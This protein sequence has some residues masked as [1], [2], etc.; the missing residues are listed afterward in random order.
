M[1]LLQCFERVHHC[2]VSLEEYMACKTSL[3]SCSFCMDSSYREYFEKVGKIIVGMTI[4]VLS[5]WMQSLSIKGNL[6]GGSSMQYVK[7]MERMEQ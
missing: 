7:Y 1:F 3:E 4:E 5:C 2:H 6:E